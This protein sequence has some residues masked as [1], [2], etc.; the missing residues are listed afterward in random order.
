MQQ[1]RSNRDTSQESTTR[2]SGSSIFRTDQSSLVTD[3]AGPQRH[4][5]MKFFFRVD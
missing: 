5:M 1:V 4:C 3:H 2:E